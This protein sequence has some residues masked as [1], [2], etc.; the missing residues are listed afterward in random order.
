MAVT[1]IQCEPHP[2]RQR[3]Y[4][5]FLTYATRTGL[6]EAMGLLS[7]R[8]SERKTLNPSVS[9]D[10]ST[11]NSISRPGGLG[12]LRTAYGSKLLPPLFVIASIAIFYWPLL[13][14]IYSI[15]DVGPDIT[16]MAVP[17]LN[18][19]AHA[20]RSGIVPVWD[21]YEMGGQSPLGEVT[22]AVLDPFSYPLLFMP[23][24]NGHVRLG[25]IQIYYV[26]LHCLAGLAAYLL[27]MDLSVRSHLAAVVAGVF[28]AIGSVPGNAIWFQV[29]TEAIYAPL[30]LMFLFRS[31][32][33]MRPL[34][35]AAVAGVLLGFSWF[36]GT[37]HIPVIMSLSC[38]TLLLVIALFGDL[39]IGLLRLAVFSGTMFFVSAPQVIPAL[40][41]GQ[42]SMRWVLLD[43]PIPGA[44]KVPFLAHLI[45]NIHPSS[46]LS[47]LVPAQGSWQ[48]MLFAGVVAVAFAVVAVVT[49]LCRARLVR[50]CLA[51]IIAGT[52]MTLSQYNMLYGVAY[53]LVPMFDKLREACFWIFLSHLALTCLLGLGLDAFIAR[54]QILLEKRIAKVLAIAGGALLIFSYLVESLGKPEFRDTGDR[55]A[56]S[57]IAALLLACLFYLVNSSLL[58]PG[59]AAALALGLLMIE[60]GNVAGRNKYPRG[61]GYNSQF[62]KPLL[63]S[64]SLAQFLRTRTDLERIDVDQKD[65]PMNFGDL[66]M[67]EEMSSH[68]GSMLAS[69]FKTRFWEPR[70]RQLYGVNYYLARKPSQSNQVEL[71]TAPSGIKIFRNPDAR[72]RVWSVHKIVSVPDYGRANDL[73]SSPSF[74]MATTSFVTGEPPQLGD[75]GSGDQVELLNRSWFSVAI[76]A[77]M[78]CAGMVVLNDNWYPGWRASVDG[79]SVPIYSAY[80]TV[81]GVVVGAGDHVVEM[82]YRPRA[83][84]LGCVL[85][86]IGLGATIWLYRQTEAQGPNL[87]A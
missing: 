25:Y 58:K 65:L 49:S 22:P 83:L 31:L 14:G 19:R 85:F 18:L 36:S 63:A 12:L 4:G 30:V 7:L 33:G 71:F 40:Q 3:L 13:S 16:V 37:H 39:R 60:H 24:K 72:P 28:Y 79:K 78:Q 80:M 45:E 43:Q 48:P 9:A 81:R 73:L 51:F 56:I 66:H 53:I 8:V 35:N 17:D 82:R 21:P 46:L 57:A 62:E 42:M 20:L 38:A 76:R 68:G 74:E 87:L 77:R 2:R 10:P 11:R 50:L 27:I 59:L 15:F 67:I 32:R 75:C 23:L 34:G 64:D 86:A 84:Y 6:S 47:I 61:H 54:D 29:V 26:L 52:L 69:V 55:F 1:C 70:A 44:A 5:K 41:W